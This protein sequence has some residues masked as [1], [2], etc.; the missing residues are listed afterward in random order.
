MK[1]V[2]PLP[3][4][5]KIK[6]SKVVSESLYGIQIQFNEKAELVNVNYPG[7]LSLA[8]VNNHVA[9]AML[10]LAQKLAEGGK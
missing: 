8:S 1:N 9:V 5:R 3:A 6:E 4:P 10:Y 2:S 7:D